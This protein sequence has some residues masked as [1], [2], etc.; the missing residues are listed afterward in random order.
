MVHIHE[1]KTLAHKV[2]LK[3]KIIVPNVVA[4]A[5]KS[6]KLRNGNRWMSMSSRPTKAT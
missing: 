4:Q 5:F 3:R 6:Q 2:N 1:D